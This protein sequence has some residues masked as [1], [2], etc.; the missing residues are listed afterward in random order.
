V[1]SGNPK[2]LGDL[3]ILNRI[4]TINIFPDFAQNGG[5][6][7]YGPE[8]QSLF[9]QAGILTGKVMGGAAISDLPVER[10]TRFRSIA[11]LKTAHLIGVTMPTSILLL[12]D[13]VIE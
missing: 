1:F 8:L 2:L 13:E 6:I 7:G 10:P 5:L 12:A 11:N 9:V 3:A 4:P